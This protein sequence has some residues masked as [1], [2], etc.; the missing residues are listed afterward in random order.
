MGG[1]I[2]NIFKRTTTAGLTGRKLRAA[3][4]ITATLGFSLFG[5]D[6]GLM[7]GLISAE[8]FKDRKSVV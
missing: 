3:V 8:Q 7:A 4:T 6:Q 2:D 1:F 5:Y